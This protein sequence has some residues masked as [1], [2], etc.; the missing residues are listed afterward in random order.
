MGKVADASINN[1]ASS[2]EDSNIETS[3]TSQTI[4]EEYPWLHG[5]PPG[6]E[7]PQL[8]LLT[9]PNEMFGGL[10]CQT[11]PPVVSVGPKKP[12]LIEDDSSFP[13][14]PA[15]RDQP[16]GNLAR[17]L[18]NVPRHRQVSVIHGSQDQNHTQMGLNEYLY[19]QALGQGVLSDVV[20]EAFGKEYNLHKL[21]LFRSSYFASLFSGLWPQGTENRAT[22]HQLSMQCDPNITREAFELALERLYGHCDPVNES[23]NLYGLLAVSNFLDLPDLEDECLTQLIKLINKDNVAAIVAFST[24]YDYGKS[25]S[26]LTDACKSFICCEGYAMCDSWWEKI[27]DA[28]LK[29]VLTHDGLFVPTEWDRC[30]FIARLY[31][32]AVRNIE[33]LEIA[34]DEAKKNELEDHSTDSSVELQS[35]ES[36]SHTDGLARLEVIKEAL[37]SGIYYAHVTPSQL[38]VLEAYRD[39]DGKPLISRSSLRDGLWLQTILGQ[40]ISKS[41]LT[42][43]RVDLVVDK[44]PDDEDDVRYYP[45]PHDGH[46][47]GKVAIEKMGESWVRFPPFRFSVM[48]DK[49]T[50][51]EED[52]RTY[53]DTFWY[54]GSFW[55]VYIQK[56]RYKKNIFQLG[57]YLY[58][59]KAD[60]S[61]ETRV[62]VVNPQPH[63]QTRKYSTDDD[64]TST[65]DLT[66]VAME[67]ISLEMPSFE[68]Y[69]IRNHYAGTVSPPL[70]RQ[71]GSNG[72]SESSSVLFGHSFSG[73][74]FSERRGP[75][76]GT[77]DQS[78]TISSLEPQKTR[79]TVNM[80]PQYI[81]QR[82][83]VTAYF[84]IYTPPRRGK[85]SL[86]CFSSSPDEFDTSQSW[87]WKSTSFW[88]LAEEEA[89]TLKFMVSVGVI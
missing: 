9:P 12:Y 22:V 77:L 7:E 17:I 68:P 36:T 84:K 2:L 61:P 19:E 39:I 21:I 58:R 20:I 13:I 26:L 50:S 25:S 64:D 6:S 32:A 5:L 73:S 57:V 62:F 79:T 80:P 15:T 40:V 8:E 30:Q 23:K 56:L 31:N 75:Y 71:T 60:V 49:V 67:N 14:L 63:S 87:G 10:S 45:V 78:K 83:N 33:P 28:I 27:P 70:F 85:P 44:K 37:N 18:S 88:S 51:L 54:A 74:S 69:V 46:T 55:N 72:E 76:F 53:S 86:T 89:G 52:K 35:V 4:A 47:V 41:P 42:R 59:G 81:D 29:E 34:T 65:E 16:P 38:S 24:A 48:F 82:K 11:S 43:P 1:M 66:T 3:S